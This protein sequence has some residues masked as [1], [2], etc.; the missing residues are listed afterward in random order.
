MNHGTNLI[1]AGWGF[2]ALLFVASGAMAS[3]IDPAILPEPWSKETVQTFEELPVQED[4]RI[5]PMRTVADYKLLRFRG[6]KGVRVKTTDGEKRDLSA[7]EWMLDVIFYP[8][9]AKH[10]PIFLVEDG[11]ALVP[12]EVDTKEKKRRDRYSYAE[13]FPDGIADP[14]RKRMAEIRGPLMQ[15]AE[16]EEE[17]SRIERMQMSLASNISEFEFLLNFMKFAEGIQVDSS[18]FPEGLKSILGDGDRLTVSTLIEKLPEIRSLG[19]TQAVTEAFTEV[20]RSLGMFMGTATGLVFIPPKDAEQE[21]WMSP[22]EVMEFGIGRDDLRPWAVERVGNLESLYALRDDRGGFE[23]KLQEIS[24]QLMGDADKRG[25]SE[26]IGAEVLY[27]RGKF[28]FWS[29]V[30]FILV[31]ILCALSWLSPQS[32]VGRLLTKIGTWSLLIPTALLIIGLA[33]RCYILGRAP[34]S[35]L[36]ETIPFIT[37]CSVIVG[38]IAEFIHRKGLALPVT[39][40]MGFVGLGLAMRFELKEGVDTMER[41]QA[42]LD[43]NYWLSTH[44]TTVTMGYSAG[45]MASFFSYVYIIGRVFDLKR[46]NAEFF[47]LLTRCVYGIICFG[48]LFSLVGT[49]LGGIWAN[50]SWGRFWGWDPKENGALMIVLWFLLILHARM[51]GYIREM[52]IHICSVIGAAIVAFSWWHVNQLGIGLHAYGF[53]DGVRQALFAFYGFQATIAVVGL[54]VLLAARKVSS[55]SSVLESG[56]A[57]VSA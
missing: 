18:K 51:G 27:H 13:L 35:N 23:T 53:I 12:L 52:G 26:K 31:F 33:L 10:Y 55:A 30:G 54:L 2:L 25:E 39:A 29:W 6:Y 14:A 41:L 47:R 22:G 16:R 17:I 19:A 5:K 49:V 20:S 57:D 15:K 43:S 36:Y 21:E 38:I 24:K 11:E 44:V 1:K 50:D 40:F 42:V 7:S 56:E 4:G 46:K 37:G 9:A 3:P 32:G 8:E 34:V 45:L 28:F 48:L